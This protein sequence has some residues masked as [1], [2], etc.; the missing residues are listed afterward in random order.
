MS[1][2]ISPLVA[3]AVRGVKEHIA[4][5]R[6]HHAETGEWPPEP[7][8]DELTEIR[9]QIMAEHDYDLEKVGRWY[10]GLDKKSPAPKSNG[11]RP[12]GQQ[13]RL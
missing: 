1:K 3:E 5:A 13:P 7:L 4:A 12:A 2:Q 9:N 6:K 11:A 8:L 10:L